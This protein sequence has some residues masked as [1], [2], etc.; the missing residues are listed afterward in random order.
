FK[1]EWH[2]TQLNIEYLVYFQTR[3]FKALIKDIFISPV[4]VIWACLKVLFTYFCLV[5]W[6]SN[7]ARLIELFRVNF[8]EPKQ[9]PA[10]WIRLIWYISR[11]HRAIAW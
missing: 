1:Q 11:A 7:S 8:L 9:P 5:W 4:P 10:F 2:L 3:S 6:L